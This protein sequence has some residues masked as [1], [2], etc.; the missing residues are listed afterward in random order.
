MSIEETAI[1]QLADLRESYVK[2][3]LSTDLLKELSTKVSA[4]APTQDLGT[5]IRKI[6]EYDCQVLMSFLGPRDT[7]VSQS[8][9]GSVSVNA[10][11]LVQALAHLGRHLETNPHWKQFEAYAHLLRTMGNL[12]VHDARGLDASDRQ[13]MILGACRVC[14]LTLAIH[15][16]MAGSKAPTPAPAP[17]PTPAFSSGISAA[18]PAFASATVINNKGVHMGPVI[19]GSLMNITVSPFPTLAQQGSSAPSPFPTLEE[20]MGMAPPSQSRASTLWV[21]NIPQSMTAERLV[22]ISGDANAKGVI[23]GKIT[24]NN[25]EVSYGFLNCSSDAAAELAKIFLEAQGYKVRYRFDN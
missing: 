19:P 9:A 6:V 24:R 8:N 11:T 4:R 17:A 10:P 23:K 2:A 16:I 25:K 1:A 5:V 3:S 18:T 20:Q 22:K 15:E 14:S 13:V 21:G 7:S 12:S